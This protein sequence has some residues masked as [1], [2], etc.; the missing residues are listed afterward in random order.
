MPEGSHTTT[1]LPASPFPGGS[2]A[3]HAQRGRRRWTLSQRLAFVYGCISFV[4]L[5]GAG[6][7]TWWQASLLSARNEDLAIA[8]TRRMAERIGSVLAQA[9]QGISVLA[10][11]NPPSHGPEACQTMLNAAHLTMDAM[12]RHLLVIDANRRI[13]CSTLASSVEYV[14]ADTVIRTAELTG[15]PVT[16]ALRQSALGLGT[17]IGAGHPIRRNG[18]HEGV[19][20]ATVTVRDLREVTASNLPNF[21]GLRVWLVDAAGESASLVGPEAPLP[22]LPDALRASLRAPHMEAGI[23]LADDQ[24]LIEAR[25][26]DDLAVIAALPERAIRAGAPL[27]VALPPLIL[28]FMLLAGLGALFW[29]VQRF[30]VAPL[31]A[32]TRRLE[33]FENAPPGTNLALD[34]EI[35]AASDVSDLIRRLGATRTTRDEAIRLRDMLLREAH[36]RIK[37]HLALVASFLRLQERQLS[38]HAALQALRAAQNRMVAIGMTYELLHDGAGQF[39]ALDK[40]LDRFCRALAARDLTEGHATQILADLAPLEVPADIAVKIGLVVNELATNALK[41]AFVGR[42]PGTI[43]VALRPAGTGGFT[44]RIA[45]DGA[46][47]P[48]E[49][50]RG[51]GLTVVDSLLRG[52]DA[53]IERQPGPGTAFLI[54]WLPRGT[55]KPVG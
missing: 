29:S 54:T 44:L 51:L 34:T 25:A 47:M 4:I 36:H 22:R 40:M 35:D 46:G 13:A 38:D 33:A 43:R 41:Y 12:V 50:S 45:D 37:N 14:G 19:V 28:A 1:L 6:L 24:F 42:G 3:A 49:P 32:A 11:M 39:V 23:A 53:S 2:D 26:T 30:V 15:R 31:E 20:L 10:S 5:L 17:V 55:P 16:G 21:Q 52:I 27:E 48:N 7:F 18:R 9:H 8:E